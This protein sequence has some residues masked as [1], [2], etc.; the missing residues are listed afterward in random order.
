MKSELFSYFG[1]MEVNWK[2]KRFGLK[3]H[4]FTQVSRVS[5]S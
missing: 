3:G 1:E 5:C 4:L 2:K